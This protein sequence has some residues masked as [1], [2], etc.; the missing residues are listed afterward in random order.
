MLSSTLRTVTYTM[1]LISPS[2]DFRKCP[3]RSV[4][5]D[6]SDWLMLGPVF[7]PIKTAQK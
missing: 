6:L 5:W 7:R 1:V 4:E 3:M 2:L